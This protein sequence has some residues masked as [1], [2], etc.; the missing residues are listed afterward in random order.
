M[1]FIYADIG[2]KKGT[3]NV[4]DKPDFGWTVKDHEQRSQDIILP[5][6]FVKRMEERKARYG[7]K[8]PELIFRSGC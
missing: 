8:M 7:A 5:G 6:K 3:I 4:P 1:A 2:F